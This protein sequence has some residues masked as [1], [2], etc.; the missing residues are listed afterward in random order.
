M[1]LH[2]GDDIFKEYL[3]GQGVAMVDYRLHIWPIP[4]V[5]LQTTTAFPQSAVPHKDTSICIHKETRTHTELRQGYDK[6][7]YCTVWEIRRCK[8]VKSWAQTFPFLQIL[9]SQAIITPSI[10][11]SYYIN[12]CE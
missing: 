5:N 1:L 7:F 3:G 11:T 4:A 9:T 8:G 6:H 10:H 2:S 12:T